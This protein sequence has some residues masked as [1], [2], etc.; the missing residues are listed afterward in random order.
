MKRK[1]SNNSTG[2]GGKNKKTTGGS[3]AIKNK[4]NKAT[5]GKGDAL[6]VAE[7]RQTADAF[8]TQVF[9]PFDASQPPRGLTS[10]HYIPV[11]VIKNQQT[12]FSTL[13]QCCNSAVVAQLFQGKTSASNL[14]SYTLRA[15]DLSG[16]SRKRVN[17]SS[18]SDNAIFGLMFVNTAHNQSG[19]HRF[20][21]GAQPAII[22]FHK[23]FVKKS[24]SIDNF[25]D[26]L[27]NVNAACSL[28]VAKRGALKSSNAS[29]AASSIASHPPHSH[30][31]PLPPF[32]ASWVS[33]G[34]ITLRDPLFRILG[35]DID[36]VCANPERLVSGLM[37]GG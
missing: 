12:I 20:M 35:L 16:A 28:A 36:R 30:G 29:K 18:T 14:A 19:I 1:R 17:H 5:R 24:I 23:V 7:A 33:L 9:V 13:L 27:V 25:A 2:G 34:L 31:R 3:A 11:N 21:R 26:K 10:S 37:H 15:L 32:L 22:S 6:S 8:L 4:N